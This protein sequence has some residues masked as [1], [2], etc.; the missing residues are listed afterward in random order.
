MMPSAVDRPL[1]EPPARAWAIGANA[2]VVGLTQSAPNFC[3]PDVFRAV[4]NPVAGRTVPVSSRR[5]SLNERRLP[6]TRDPPWRRDI[7]T[8]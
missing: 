4:I 7:V 8:R 3:A 1:S 6:H 5:I 2:P